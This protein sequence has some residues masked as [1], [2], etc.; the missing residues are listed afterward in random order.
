MK[1]YKNGQDRNGSA[2]RRQLEFD[3]IVDQVKRRKQ[4]FITRLQSRLVSTVTGCLYYEG[5]QDHK[6]YPVMNFK[7]RGQHVQIGVH[8]V[9][10][11][12]GA[13]G[14]IPRGM[15]AAHADECT[16]RTCVRHVALQHYKDNAS[17]WHKRSKSADRSKSA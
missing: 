10:A 13:C 3:V 15:E 17:T 2:A 9:F 12:L 4:A 14:P 7:Y 16:S 6:G 5:A 1:R 11:I 8:R